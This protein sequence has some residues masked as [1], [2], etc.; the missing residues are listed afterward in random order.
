MN[1]PMIHIH[2]QNRYDGSANHFRRLHRL[3]LFAGRSD[4]N[5]MGQTA[6]RRSCRRHPRY[7]GC[8]GEGRRRQSMP[9]E[10]EDSSVGAPVV[11]CGMQMT[12]STDPRASWSRSRRAMLPAGVHARR[13]LDSLLAAV[14][15]QS[16]NEYGGHCRSM[17]ST[18]TTAVHL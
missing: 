16:R 4:P 1:T 6:P 12:S 18:G 10:S 2:A 9:Q 7:P 11:G 8:E 13:E 3:S 17:P 5:F 15:S 14:R